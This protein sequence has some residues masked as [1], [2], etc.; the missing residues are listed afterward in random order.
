MLAKLAGLIFMEV[1]RNLRNF[2]I[3]RPIGSAFG[4]FGPSS[5]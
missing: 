2:L 4:Y 5:P 1:I 3:G